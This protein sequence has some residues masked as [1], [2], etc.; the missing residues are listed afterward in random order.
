M[1]FALAE[2]EDTG[3]LNCAVGGYSYCLNGTDKY[4]CTDTGFAACTL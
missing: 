4:N 2:Y 1:T 3:C